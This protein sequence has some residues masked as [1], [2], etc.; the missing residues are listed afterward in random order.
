V[1]QRSRREQQMQHRLLLECAYAAMFSD[2]PPGLGL[3]AAQGGS[4]QRVAQHDDPKR[5]QGP[6]APVAEAAG[7][8]VAWGAPWLSAAGGGG[9]GSGALQGGGGASFSW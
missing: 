3:G 8:A 1:Q 2:E 6:P 9:G 4:G 5:S 7:V